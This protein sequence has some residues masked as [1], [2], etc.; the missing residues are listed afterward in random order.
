VRKIKAGGSI[1]VGLMAQVSALEREFQELVNFAKGLHCSS[2]R[3][4]FSF[5][6]SRKLLD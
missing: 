4:F 1:V 2:L 3:V 5:T 6:S